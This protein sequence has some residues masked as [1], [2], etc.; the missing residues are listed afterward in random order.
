MKG[1]KVEIVLG[2]FDA[3]DGEVIDI[4]DNWLKLQK[5]NKLIFVQIEKIRRVMSSN[6]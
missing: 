5:K 3:V 1:K 6:K 4:D 2:A